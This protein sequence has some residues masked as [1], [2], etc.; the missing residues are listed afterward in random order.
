MCVSSKVHDCLPLT[1]VRG[2]ASMKVTWCMSNTADH[3]EPP[4]C[5]HVILHECANPLWDHKKSCV[6]SHLLQSFLGRWTFTSKDFLLVHASPFII[7]WNAIYSG[8]TPWSL[9]CQSC[10]VEKQSRFNWRESRCRRLYDFGPAQESH[11]LSYFFFN[12]SPML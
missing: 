2:K 6:K 8:N 9:K 5:L 10:V 11:S 4:E 7:I 1:S 12:M 3:S